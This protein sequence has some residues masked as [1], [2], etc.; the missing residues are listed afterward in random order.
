MIL[1]ALF[2]LLMLVVW[3]NR[4]ARAQE[5]RISATARLFRRGVPPGQVDSKSWLGAERKSSSPI[6]TIMARSSHLLHPPPNYRVKE[7]Q[8]KMLTT[9][10]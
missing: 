3:L 6:A 10:Y 4:M 5:A 1:F 2:I 8:I 9:K 7:G